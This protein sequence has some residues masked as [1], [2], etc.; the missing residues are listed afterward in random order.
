MHIL[1]RFLTDMFTGLN[2]NTITAKKGEFISLCCSAWDS[3]SII[4]SIQP[5][6][7]EYSII[8]GNLYSNVTGGIVIVHSLRETINELMNTIQKTSFLKINSKKFYIIFEDE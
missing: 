2:G 8:S 3:E 1:E 5:I 6:G 7:G 4:K